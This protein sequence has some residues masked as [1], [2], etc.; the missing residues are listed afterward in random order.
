MSEGGK[1]G[2]QEQ[3]IFIEYTVTLVY[4][5]LSLSACVCFM[6]TEQTTAS[7]EG[8]IE[9]HF[10]LHR[11]NKIDSKANESCIWMEWHWKHEDVNNVLL[12]LCWTFSRI[13]T[14]F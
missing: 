10:P 3:I 2:A 11:W 13:Q 5:I 4:W 14:T 9:T 7:L 12:C 1:K 6:I 8:A